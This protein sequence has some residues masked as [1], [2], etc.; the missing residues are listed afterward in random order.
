M[1]TVSCAAGSTLESAI[2]ALRS[3]AVASPS[4]GL[5][6]LAPLL[7]NLSRQSRRWDRLVEGVMFPQSLWGPFP[8]PEPTPGTFRTL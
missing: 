6:L 5:G 3:P 2:K 7:C 4:V 8:K 1:C